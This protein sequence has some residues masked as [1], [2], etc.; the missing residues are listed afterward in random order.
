MVCKNEFGHNYYL[1]FR[2]G[3][4]YK[5]GISSNSRINNDK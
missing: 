4:Y 2:F 1:A 5:N 3:D